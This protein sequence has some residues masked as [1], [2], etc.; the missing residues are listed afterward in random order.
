MSETGD[1]SWGHLADTECF[2]R[3]CLNSDY[4]IISKEDLNLPQYKKSTQACHCMIY[5]RHTDKVFGIYHPRAAVLMQMR[6]DGYIGFPGGLI[7]EGED[8]VHGLNRELVEEIN[9]DIEKVPVQEEHYIVSHWNSKQQLSLH[10]YAREVSLEDF[11]Q[12]EQ[13]S[14]LADDYGSE[15]MG[16]LRVPLYTMGDGYRGF[17]T[18]LTNAFVGNSRQ[19]LLHTLN[20]LGLMSKDEIS[21]ALSAK[22]VPVD[23]VMD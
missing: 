22:P 1:R 9:L 23:P 19:Q 14:L 18:F 17:P 21:K 10:F 12:I 4:V 7:D 16:L 20:H 8:L 5:S 2:G 13:N 11:K 15:V 3:S 6:F